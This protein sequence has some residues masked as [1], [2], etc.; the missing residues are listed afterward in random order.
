MATIKVLCFPVGKGRIYKDL[1][2]LALMAATV[3]AL[4]AQFGS[5]GG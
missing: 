1:M 3:A 2:A 5:W 4:L